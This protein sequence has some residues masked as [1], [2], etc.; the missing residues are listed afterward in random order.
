MSPHPTCF[1][2]TRN[3][4]IP[5][6][7]RNYRTT[8]CNRF[9]ISTPTSKGRS[10]WSTSIHPYSTSWPSGGWSR[11]GRNTSSTASGG[12]T[13]SL[14]PSWSKSS[15]LYPSAASIDSATSFSSM[16]ILRRI[17]R[18]MI[19]SCLEGWA[20]PYFC[21][22][23]PPTKIALKSF[24]TPSTESYSTNTYTNLNL[25]TQFW[26]LPRDSAG[27]SLP[28][29]AR[30]DPAQNRRDLPQK[31]RQRRALTAVGPNQQE[32]GKGDLERARHLS[33]VW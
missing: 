11:N 8:C 16:L 28:P 12:S 24:K 9:S 29:A 13:S 6:W 21:P 7:D 31:L 32:R 10:P 2:S 33:G 18:S 30:P 23:H 3:F 19:P 22:K 25:G 27:A 20:R 17:W 5:T 1:I 26:R 4:T 15:R 14:P